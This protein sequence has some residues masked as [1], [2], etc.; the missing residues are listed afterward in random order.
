MARI[1][2]HL[3]VNPLA[4]TKVNDGKIT[5]EIAMQEGR[6]LSNHVSCLSEM[7]EVLCQTNLFASAC[8]L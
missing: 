8:P 4:E 7:E 2:N 5:A 6:Y 3:Q 1:S